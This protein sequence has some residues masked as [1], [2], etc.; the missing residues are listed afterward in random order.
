MTTATSRKVGVISSHR[1]LYHHCHDVDGNTDGGGGVVF[2]SVH[3]CQ[4]KEMVSPADGGHQ[5]Q[6]GGHWGQHG[7]HRGQLSVTFHMMTIIINFNT[8]HLTIINSLLQVS[9][10]I[11]LL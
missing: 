1:H 2:S 6:H 11:A 3:W 9:R 7:G 5:G 10:D 8:A 4:M